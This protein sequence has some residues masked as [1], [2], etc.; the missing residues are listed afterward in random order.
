MT[1]KWVIPTW[2]LLAALITWNLLFVAQYTL[3]MLPH[4][5]AVD[6]KLVWHNKFNVLS[7]IF[8]IFIN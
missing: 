2:F 5:E 7:K 6:F 3:G 4:G 8:S 1:K